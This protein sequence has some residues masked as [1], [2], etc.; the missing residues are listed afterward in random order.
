MSDEELR[1]R[2]EL[3]RIEHRDLDEAVRALLESGNQDQLRVARLKKRKLQLR[4]RI[5]LIE[6]QLIPDILA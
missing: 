4:D 5:I 2:L 3:L 1:Q 6:N